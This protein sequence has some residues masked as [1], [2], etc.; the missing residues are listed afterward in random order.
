MG[1]EAT[2][3]RICQLFV[4]RAMTRRR[5][6]FSPSRTSSTR[7][8]VSECLETRT[9]LSANL[10]TPDLDVPISSAIVRNVSVPGH[11]DGVEDAAL[12]D[13]HGDDLSGKDGPTF[14]LGM[15]LTRLYHEYEATARNGSAS[16]IRDFQPSNPLIRSVASSVL[17]EGV[18]IDNPAKLQTQLRSLGMTSIDTAGLIV[19]GWLPMQRIRDLTG[20]SELRI[21][22]P[23]YH[24]VTNAGL[25]PGQGDIALNADDARAAA[26]VDGSGI[27]VGVLSDSYNALGGAS[28]DIASGDLPAN[29]VTVIED[30]PFGSDE[31]R[32]M[33]QLVHDVAPGASLSFATAGTGQA[34]FANNIRR[35][36][37]AGADVIVDDISYLLAPVFQDGLVAQAVEEVAADGV[38]YFSS[39]GNQ[40]NR[41]H[42][43]NYDR[44]DVQDQQGGSGFFHDWDPGPEQDT[45][46]EITV[47]LFSFQTL[48]LHWDQPYGSLGGPGPATDVDIY[49]YAADGQTIVAQ[50][51]NV[52]NIG[53][54][55]SEI[56]SFFNIGDLDVD[57]EAGPDTTFNIAISVAD[58][59]D[60]TLL[61]YT[62][63]S[64]LTVNE[65]Y[66]PSG[67]V[68]QH[69]NTPGGASVAAAAYF[70]TP[71]FGEDPPLLNDFSSLGGVPIL[72][73]TNGD[74]LDEREIRLK[75]DFTGP[76]GTNT[77]FFGSDIPNDT[78]AFPNFFGTSAA[79][80][81]LAAVAALMLDSAG[82]PESLSPDFVYQTMIDS[83]ID[84]LERTSTFGFGFTTPIPQGQDYDFYSGYGLVD[85]N[86]AVL[87]VKF[88][89]IIEGIKFM[90]LDGDGVRD[91]GEPGVPNFII[92][93]DTNG[94]GYIGVGEPIT[95]TDENGYYSF[96]NLES[97]SYIL[98]EAETP[99]W[100]LRAPLGTVELELAF[101]EVPRV[102]FANAPMFDYG[103]AP[104]SYG[105][106]VNAGGPSHGIRP[107]LHLG[108]TVD[109]ELGV[110]PSGD[111]VDDDR[112][113]TND[114][115]GVVFTSGML[116][117]QYATASVVATIGDNSPA[118][119]Q[120]WIDFNRNGR[121]DGD[122]EQIARD[123]M[124]AEGDNTV[125]FFV[126]EWAAPGTSFARF[127]YGYERGI[128]P[129]GDAMAG[130]VE[131]YQLLIGSNSGTAL[132]V[133]N[134]SY[135]VDPGAANINLDVLA[136]DA[137]GFGTLTITD[138]TIPSNGG[139]AEI[140]ADGMS[141]I[142]GP[143]GGF[144]GTET[145]TYSVSNGIGSSGQATVTVV[146]GTPSDI[147]EL[148]AFDDA[149]DLLLGTSDNRLN[150]LAN[151]R[152]PQG[153]TLTIGNLTEPTRGGTVSVA[154]DGRAI[155]YNAAPGFLG[156]ESFAYTL[157]TSDGQTDTAIVTI[158]VA[159]SSEEIQARMTL[160]VTDTDGNP[161]SQIGVNQEFVLQG[162]V[163]DISTPPEGV[164]AA[165]VDVN[166]AAD[167][168]TATG[169]IS[170]GPDYPNLRN[171]SIQ[172]GL[173]DEIGATASSEILGSAPRL[174]FSVPMQSTA[175]GTIEFTV[176][177][178]DIVP[179]HGWVLFGQSSLLNAD[180]LELV[181]TSLVV[182][183]GGQTAVT[184]TNSFTN[185]VNQLDVN[186][187]GFV[188]GIDA[189]LIINRLNRD[190]GGAL[191]DRSVD[192]AYIDVNRD[193]FLSGIDALLVINH[194]NEDARAAQQADSRESRVAD[195]E[196]AMAD[197]QSIGEE[198]DDLVDSLTDDLG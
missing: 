38:A 188:S 83:S 164:F 175:S 144:E 103:D 132:T 112:I 64:S 37:D 93:L 79:A 50:S 124:L 148:D 184:N 8:L 143:A 16:A 167:L 158:D 96:A 66:N 166:F 82:G 31:G 10:G 92:H 186:A 117:G 159:P 105:T 185:P 156:T 194:L 40:S 123:L 44:S 22:R 178:A 46:Q 154:G 127:R 74:R 53:G 183:A 197:Y 181:G 84:I 146:V 169:P 77:T 86:A 67:T 13:F 168:A 63:W 80:P 3:D 102:D 174:L 91:E 48:T 101:G 56:I 106:S 57:G 133:R 17:V 129:L 145:F 191:S 81:H 152:I 20:L 24:A 49:I 195:V 180:A 76:D 12:H 47:P 126:P 11:L 139:S 120:A 68:T 140:A 5:E 28:A 72:F 165:Y 27:H 71:A 119:L 55:S 121:W 19:S 138:V 147:T 65:F 118:V 170:W 179:R 42:E 23:V 35:L 113:G 75:P 135:S 161:I 130:E 51:N 98:R 182:G 190:E 162:S 157:S 7:R 163:Q 153:V 160:A 70:N 99:G 134:D 173:L 149:Y 108:A 89:G 4:K 59:P 189:L 171:G 34:G 187:D 128:G 97:G 87:S 193:G 111:G 100:D 155:I 60:P 107:G 177:P 90:D 62:I 52:N 69:H 196:A 39:A 109:G 58:G 141:I 32:A 114:E 137:S 85:A 172:P 41:S 110:E 95:I 88:E 104:D 94:D 21:A 198:D 36:A 73:D 14:R 30:L 54:D 26:G 122:E 45:M 151:D 25:V 136:N 9:L 15:D 115:D 43:G 125:R 33:L 78:D 6:S 192:D 142:Y 150:V 2:A 61:K 131:D 29:G 1:A 116:P 18:A 176:D